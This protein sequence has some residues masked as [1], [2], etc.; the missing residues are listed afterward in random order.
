MEHNKSFVVLEAV[1]KVWRVLSR[2]RWMVPVIV[3]L[4][5]AVSSLDARWSLTVLT[6]IFGLALAFLGFKYL[7]VNPFSPMAMIRLLF[8]QDGASLQ[9]AL[10]SLGCYVG[11]LATYLLI[12]PVTGMI[13]SLADAVGGDANLM[14]A[15]VYAIGATMISGVMFVLHVRRRG[16]IADPPEGEKPLPEAVENLPGVEASC[17]Y[18][19]EATITLMLVTCALIPAAFLAGWAWNVLAS[20]ALPLFVHS[21][22]EEHRVEVTGVPAS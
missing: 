8:R 12:L 17:V 16:F 11:A 4:L 2:P 14:F 18:W 5:A 19:K 1:K 10:L 6:L 21:V 13:L 20:L 9:E 7:G 3:L 15:L 22:R